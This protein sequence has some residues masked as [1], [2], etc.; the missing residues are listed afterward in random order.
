MS[1]TGLRR[2]LLP[3]GPLRDRGQRAYFV[4]VDTSIDVGAAISNRRMANRRIFGWNRNEVLDCS[5]SNDDDSL[6]SWWADCSVMHPLRR[7]DSV[8]AFQH[9]WVNMICDRIPSSLMGRLTSLECLR[10]GTSRECLFER[11]L[12]PVRIL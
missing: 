6:S 8:R 2:L 7:K 4:M 5:N 1:A 11:C 12:D 9:H 3:S 10:Y